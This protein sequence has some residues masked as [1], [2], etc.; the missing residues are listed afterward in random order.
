VAS[1]QK[2][3]TEVVVLVMIFKFFGL[4][5]GLGPDGGVP[6]GVGLTIPAGDGVSETP[7]RKTCP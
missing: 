3:E 5:T 6:V 4:T 7:T 2:R 1:V